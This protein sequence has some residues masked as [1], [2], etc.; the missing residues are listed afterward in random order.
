MGK[1]KIPKTVDE[2]VPLNPKAEYQTDD[3]L[4]KADGCTNVSI[5]QADYRQMSLRCC[6][7]S[8]CKARAKLL[9]LMIQ[10]S[11]DGDKKLTRLLKL[12]KL[13]GTD[14]IITD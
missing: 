5:W 11:M 9:A 6:D 13:D 4:I 1:D 8:E 14:S 7:N 10:T 12:Q 3:C 2:A